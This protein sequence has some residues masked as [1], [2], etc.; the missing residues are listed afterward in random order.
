MDKLFSG[1]SKQRAINRLAEFKRALILYEARLGGQLFGAVNKG[2]RREFF[3]L[4]KHTWVWHEEWTDN[5]GTRH[6]VS[7][8]YTVRPHG[9]WKSQNNGS[10]QPLSEEKYQNFHKTILF[11][12]QQ[13]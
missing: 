7:T 1:F 3:C 12:K 11:Y 13:I 4:D 10:S 8:R 2:Q 6:V 9:I 5:S